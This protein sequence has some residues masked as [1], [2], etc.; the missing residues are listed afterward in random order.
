MANF[1]S[2]IEHSHHEFIACKF[3]FGQNLKKCEISLYFL[4]LRSIVP[5][6]ECMNGSGLRLC[7]RVFPDRTP[8]DALAFPNH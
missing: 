6:V 8:R 3:E 1:P 7:H 2:A 4:N 5:A